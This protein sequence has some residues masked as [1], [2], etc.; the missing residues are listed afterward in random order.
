ML[1]MDT[2]SSCGSVDDQIKVCC[3]CVIY[4]SC[5][6]VWPVKEKLAAIR[7]LQSALG[8]KGFITLG[9]PGHQSHVPGLSSA[10]HGHLCS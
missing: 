8:D 3:M 1:R 4:L 5:M 7:Q 10:V 2:T 6:C 9:V